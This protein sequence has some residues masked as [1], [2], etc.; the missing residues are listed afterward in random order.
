MSNEPIPLSNSSAGYGCWYWGNGCGAG[1]NIM[2][3]ENPY[4]RLK[5]IAIKWAGS[6]I[7]P[8]TRIM[9]T[10]PKEKLPG[11]WDLDKLFERVAAAKQLGYMV[12]LEADDS[13]LKVLYRKLPDELPLELR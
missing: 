9:W 1:A 11:Y 5:R 6:A 13:G 4:N 12:I 7:Y 8:H 3:P 10:Y 2:K